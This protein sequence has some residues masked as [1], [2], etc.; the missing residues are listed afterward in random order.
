MTS[1]TA[2]TKD[3]SKAHDN[4]LVKI[5]VKALIKY[6]GTMLPFGMVMYILCHHMLEGCD[7]L[8]YFD[9]IGVTFKRMS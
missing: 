3:F 7:L 2:H 8:F 1:E 5:K 4:F 6:P 9:F